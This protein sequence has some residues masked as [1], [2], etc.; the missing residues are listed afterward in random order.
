VL[1]QLGQRFAKATG[2]AVPVEAAG[3]LALN[4]RLTAE[5]LQII[6]EGLSNV[7]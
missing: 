6:A 5:V 2:I 1:R 7:R 3:D 4:D